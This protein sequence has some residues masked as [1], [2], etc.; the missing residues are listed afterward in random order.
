MNVRG[1]FGS[2]G[3]GINSPQNAY[4]PQ[5]PGGSN[6]M[7]PPPP[8]VFAPPQQPSTSCHRYT[9]QTGIAATGSV[10]AGQT[11]PST[12]WETNALIAN[13]ACWLMSLMVAINV[14]AV[15]DQYILLYDAATIAGVDQ[16]K[17]AL[18][19]LGP[20][21]AGDTLILSEPVTE[22]YHLAG[23]QPFKGWPF[24]RGIVAMT[25]GSPRVWTEGSNGVTAY[26]ARVQL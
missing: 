21:E 4:A 19:T 11:Q 10:G 18:L 5:V 16:N 2:T 15:G 14:G 9:Y 8:Q 20:L 13:Q 17:P 23:R 7:A 24:D 26:T 3:S 22:Q 1:P 6:I 12:S 25:S